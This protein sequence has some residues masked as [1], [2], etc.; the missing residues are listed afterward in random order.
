MLLRSI[1]FLFVLLWASGFVGAR[2]GL[3]YAEP[4]TLLAIRML[5][6]IALFLLLIVLLRRRVPTGAAFW[7]S[8]V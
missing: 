6:N 5:A 4:A 8:C 1:P 3:Q 2:L 7:H